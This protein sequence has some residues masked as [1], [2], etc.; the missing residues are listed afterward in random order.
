[1]SFKKGYTLSKVMFSPEVLWRNLE[2]VCDLPRRNVSN[3]TLLKST[4]VFSYSYTH[5]IP[6]TLVQKTQN[7]RPFPNGFINLRYWYCW[8]RFITFIHISKMSS[9][10]F[11][12]RNK[13]NDRNIINS[14]SFI[15]NFIFPNIILLKYNFGKL[16]PYPSILKYSYLQI[17][18]NV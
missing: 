16:L 10:P 13:V 3:I 8:I 15:Y 17:F 4:N 6:H 14:T 11:E 7:R 2:I 9:K 5:S 1:M 12:F 18:L